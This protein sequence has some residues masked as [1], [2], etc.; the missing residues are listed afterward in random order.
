M[1]YEFRF[2][3]ATLLSGLSFAVLAL[4]IPLLSHEMELSLTENSFLLGIF[5][6]AIILFS[7]LWGTLS[8]RWRQRKPFLV[9]GTL[10]FALASLLQ[11]FTSN[12]IELL[13]LRFVQGAAF[14]TNSM[15]TALFSDYFGTRASRSFGFFS[16]ANALGFGIGSLGAG[17]VAEGWGV[18][19]AFILSAGM[20][21]LGALVIQVGLPELPPSARP[22]VKDPL[23]SGLSYLYA[24]VFVR[25]SAAM[26]LWSIF[27]IYLTNFVSNKALI[28]AVNS[29]NMLV[30]PIFMILMGRLAERSNKLR[31]VLWGI[32]GSIATFA[33]YAIASDVWL[34]VLGQIM[35]AISWSAMSIG[36]NLYLIERVSEGARGRAFGY[37]QASFTTAAAMGPF[38]SGPLSD[39]FGVHRMIL[40]VGGLMG[41]SLPFL[42]RLRVLE[43][44][45]RDFTKAPTTQKPL[46]NG[47][48]AGDV[49]S[50]PDEIP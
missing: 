23:P 9:I 41:L 42:W 16:A 25:Q 33:V 3:I 21:L 8:D 49:H 7:P 34:I 30:Q 39:A 5:S 4:I 15:L 17:V 50:A 29:S 19:A 2:A 36:I 31:L 37:L 43:P 45:I 38:L 26:A 6:L 27:P 46:D 24:T 32:I 28:G 35:I 44:K 12:F 10:V 13:V 18:H 47:A 48:I 11:F 14:A 40:I 1:R 20:A 22:A